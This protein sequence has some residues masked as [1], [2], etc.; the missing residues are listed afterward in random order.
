MYY[1]LEEKHRSRANKLVL[2]SGVFFSL[3]RVL[4]EIR[5]GDYYSAAVCGV[6]AAVVLILFVFFSKKNIE[7]FPLIFS[8]CLYISYIGAS[9][10]IGSF[11]Y[12]YAYYVLVLLICAIYF[13]ARH[14]L[15]LFVVTQVV[16]IFI[17]IF[18]LPNY[19]NGNIWVHFGL[20]F[21]S[22]LMILL[23]VQFSVKKSNEVNS[24]F[25]SFGALMNIT[26]N[27]LILID[28][29][30]KVK[31]LSRSVYKVLG[32][33]EPESYVGKNFLD[34]F[35]ENTVKELF[36]DVAKKRVFFENYQK[37]SIGGRIKTFDVFADKMSENAT[38]G[39]FFMFNDISEIIRLK[40]LA[41]QDSIMDGLI[42][43]PNR[44][45]FD[46][47]IINE[48]NRALRDKVNLSFLMIDIDFFKKYNDTYGHSQG[49]ELLK[50]AGEVF[51]NSLKRSTDF[52]AR[53][54]GEEFG[55]LLHAT[56]SFQ[57]S[58]TAERIRKA[59][60]DEIIVTRTGE[61]TRFTVSIGVCTLIPRVDLE[62]NYIVEEADKALYKAKENGRN[63]VQVADWV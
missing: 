3:L 5:M 11:K 30:N 53:L 63:Q 60:E 54:G 19:I 58:V 21:C 42:Q 9:F 29:D 24:A 36:G 50:V 17:T 10:A 28:E 43:I 57:A 37:I 13:N 52:V 26:P 61:Q 47:Q 14:F 33:R 45:G 7:I 6:I 48:W 4:T 56:N 59:V 44:R 41:E 46:R 8:F 16:N 1:G 12:F 35:K 49:D 20:I 18:E 32:I 38:D 25:T 15:I 51:K 34:L 27:V 40:E 31:Y 62:H 39:M 55:V 2:F 22:G 23:M